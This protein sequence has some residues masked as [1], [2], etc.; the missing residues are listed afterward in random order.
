[1]GKGQA[2]VTKMTM[3][4]KLTALLN[5]RRWWT[6]VGGA[7]VVAFKDVLGMDEQTAWG[8][9]S[10]AIAWIVGDSIKRTE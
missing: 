9:V 4:E 7:V 10:L 5:S 8:I 3:W 1:M 2:V 6:A